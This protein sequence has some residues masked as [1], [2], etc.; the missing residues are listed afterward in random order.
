MPAPQFKQYRFPL[1]ATD[2]GR[3]FACINVDELAFTQA[4]EDII[5][6]TGGYYLS[7]NSFTIKKD[8]EDKDTGALL[9][10]DTGEMVLDSPEEM[11]GVSDGSPIY[12]DYSSD[13]ITL[14]ED[15]LGSRTKSYRIFIGRIKYDDTVEYIHCGDFSRNDV[16][17]DDIN[18]FE[19]GSSSETS[20]KKCT[21]QFPSVTDKLR[22]LKIKDIVWDADNDFVFD[23]PEAFYSGLKINNAATLGSTFEEYEKGKDVKFNESTAGGTKAYGIFTR[24]N[25]ISNNETITIGSVTYTFK[26]TLGSNP[27][28]V[29][30]GSLNDTINNLAAAINR[31]SFAA[32]SK[33]TASTVEHPD[34]VALNPPFDVRFWIP[35]FAGRATTLFIEAKAVGNVSIALSDT[36]TNGSWG[37]SS[38]RGGSD[39]VYGIMNPPSYHTLEMSAQ[40]NPSYIGF[41]SGAWGITHLKIFEKIFAQIGYELVD[42]DSTPI[43]FLRQFWDG[44]AFPYDTTEYDDIA[45]FVCPWNVYFGVSPNG[46]E[47]D[48][49]DNSFPV[50]V[51]MKG[52]SDGDEIGWVPSDGDWVYIHGCSDTQL[53]GY[54]RIE[55]VDDN[56]FT[57]P[58]ITGT[59][60]TGG[61]VSPCIKTPVTWEPET[62]LIDVLKDMCLQHGFYLRT[63]LNQT[64]GE[65]QVE[66]RDRS[67]RVPVEIPAEIAKRVVDSKESEFIPPSHLTVSFKGDTDKVYPI[68]RP[69]LNEDKRIEIKLPFRIHP[70]G[71]VVGDVYG[72]HLIYDGGDIEKQAGAQF[73]H[74]VKGHANV[75]SG[76]AGYPLIYLVGNTNPFPSTHENHGYNNTWDGFFAGN[77]VNYLEIT[78]SYLDQI[79][80][81]YAHSLQLSGGLQITREFNQIEHNGSTLWIEPNITTTIRR[82]N[83]M[84]VKS[85]EINYVTDSFKCTLVENSAVA[86]VQLYRDSSDQTTGASNTSGRGSSSNTTG[87]SGTNVSL[88]SSIVYLTDVH[89]I[90]DETT[91]GGSPHILITDSVEPLV[92]TYE[93]TIS[94]LPS[95]PLVEE[96]IASLTIGGNNY[97]GINGITLSLRF[98][99]NGVNVG[100]QLDQTINGSQ[101]WSAVFH[102]NG[103]KLQDGDV[104]GVKI[105]ATNNAALQMSYATVYEHPRSLMVHGVSSVTTTPNNIFRFSLQGANSGVDYATLQNNF[106]LG[107]KDNLIGEWF[108]S[109]SSG[110]LITF[111]KGQ[112]ITFDFPGAAYGTNG[113]TTNA[114]STTSRLYGLGLLKLYRAMQ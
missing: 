109:L 25:T 53:N 89:R 32:G 4:E 64:T 102:Y 94:D 16:R 41:P 72:R 2:I 62:S 27:N 23:H 8:L 11:K 90:T 97:T 91:F 104:I 10:A 86:E 21:I 38:M 69:S 39:S 26:T 15:I 74:N 98:T 65:P 111:I 110:S 55:A 56:T 47:I 50:T 9:T 51:T 1:F 84:Y 3:Y 103:Q 113:G 83:D 48:T 40:T 14:F 114:N 35:T 101:Y 22:K 105:W 96:W 43:T 29:L 99:L 46:R 54:K 82:T 76:W 60:G 88:N 17:F 6:L 57:I 66:L 80:T 87:T 12:Y 24:T 30:I 95:D 93:F 70:F 36:I 18:V 81:I 100:G 44:S 63:S 5:E 49:T 33:F 52:L 107:V 73:L 112:N 61:V 45:D 20:R 13:G 59:G 28:E 92:N 19:G 34:V 79:A 108:A 42:Y 78:E 58:L 77:L 85:V 31:V 67:A 7:G 68:R 71:D 37:S 75:P 106:S